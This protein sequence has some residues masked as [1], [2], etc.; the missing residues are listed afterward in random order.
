M[1]TFQ[2]DHQVL[3][4]VGNFSADLH[5]AFNREH[6]ASSGFHDLNLLEFVY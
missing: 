5:D 3:N 6:R 1:E 2:P 4:L